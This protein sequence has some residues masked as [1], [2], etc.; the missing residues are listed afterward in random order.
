MSAAVVM[1]TTYGVPVEAAAPQV[2]PA[3]TVMYEYG[4]PAQ[5]TY[6]IAAP[7][8]T[9]M[10]QE[11]VYAAAPAQTTYGFAAAPV[12]AYVPQQTTYG[13]AATGSAIAPVEYAAPAVPV[14]ETIYTTVEAPAVELAPMSVDD[15]A[16]W[17]ASIEDHLR[18]NPVGSAESF[19]AVPEYGATTITAAPETEAPTGE[20]KKDKKKKKASKRKG[21]C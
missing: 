19:V 17:R 1:Q 16:A 5:T 4:A 8:A 14:P 13:I 3:S 21:C 11:V 6:G 10:P 20:A 15:Y 2:V 18:L 9:Y 7:A 12:E